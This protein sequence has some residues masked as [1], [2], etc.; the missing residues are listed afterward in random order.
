ML[1][2]ETEQLGHDW[3]QEEQNHVIRRLEAILQSPRAT[4][5]DRQIAKR[6]LDDYRKMR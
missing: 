1:S 6:Q 2:N 5:T 3:L 4:E